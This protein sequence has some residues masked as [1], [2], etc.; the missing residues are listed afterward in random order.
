MLPLLL[1][2]LLLLEL[3]LLLLLLLSLLLCS[4][5]IWSLGTRNPSPNSEQV[6]KGRDDFGRIR[7]NV[8]L[9]L[10][11]WFNKKG[12]DYLGTWTLTGCFRFRRESPSK[13]YNVE[14]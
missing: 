12:R 4:E 8:L 14:A 1:L 2:L 11:G 13:G 5:G 7:P 6:L 3:L 9:L 10:G